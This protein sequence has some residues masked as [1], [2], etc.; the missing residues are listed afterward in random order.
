MYLNRRPN[1]LSVR[2]VALAAVILSTAL[3]APISTQAQTSAFSGPACTAAPS[4]QTDTWPVAGTDVLSTVAGAP[5]T[6]SA[7]TLLANDSKGTAPLSVSGAGPTSTNGGT[8]T[9]SGPYTYTAAPGFGGPDYSPSPLAAAATPARTPAGIVHV[10][11][12]R[13]LTPPTVSISAPANGATISSNVVVRASAADNV[14]VAGVSFFDGATRIGAEV[15]ASPYHT[16][17]DLTAATD[18]PHALTAVARDASGHSA[19]SAAGN[20]TVTH[21]PPP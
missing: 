20:V 9:G 15:T 3:I 6:F 18:G 17:W 12:G 8:I 14:G 13:D 7:A 5:L 4:P 11:V 10:S 2:A 1:T 16:T 19:T 21:T